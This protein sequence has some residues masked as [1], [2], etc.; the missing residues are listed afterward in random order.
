MIT[1]KLSKSKTQKAIVI[2]EREK[3]VRRKTSNVQ[4][5][6]RDRNE[7]RSLAESPIKTTG[8]NKSERYPSNKMKDSDL[9]ILPD[10]LEDFVVVIRYHD[11][12]RKSVY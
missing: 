10:D 12:A 1:Q 6:K 8:I 11:Q 9:T 2:S 7:E 4:T 5:T 3:M